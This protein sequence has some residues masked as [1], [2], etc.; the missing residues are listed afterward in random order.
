MYFWWNLHSIMR[1]NWHLDHFSAILEWNSS[2]P[3]NIDR[4]SLADRFIATMLCIYKVGIIF[5]EPLKKKPH[6]KN[7]KTSKKKKVFCKKC[8]KISQMNINFLKS[9]GMVPS[10]SGICIYLTIEFRVHILKLGFTFILH[11]CFSK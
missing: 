3:R 7:K 5:W 8:S 2:F 1:D 10:K 9:W 4:Y 11:I 6:F